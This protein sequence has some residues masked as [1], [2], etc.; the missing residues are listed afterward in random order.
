MESKMHQY[1]K[2]LRDMQIPQKDFSAKIGVSLRAL[3]NGMK[4]ENKRYTALI[5]ALELM[6]AEKR[7]EWL[8]LP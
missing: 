8:K 4:T 6:S 7:D 1:G 2:R 3:Q 5:H